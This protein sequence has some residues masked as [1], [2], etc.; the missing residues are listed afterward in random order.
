M[1]NRHERKG[2]GSDYTHHAPCP[3]DVSDPQ[4]LAWAGR[5]LYGEINWRVPLADMLQVNRRSMQRWLNGTNGIPIGVWLMLRG[6]MAAR[7]A[8]QRL[9][10]EVM[11]HR[12]PDYQQQIEV[13]NVD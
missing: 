6:H 7:I 12:Q 13:P 1:A 3:P 8:E 10:N 11:R 2:E 9:C 4:L 5:L